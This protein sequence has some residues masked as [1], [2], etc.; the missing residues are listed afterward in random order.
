[1]I[2][3]AM[4]VRLNFTMAAMRFSLFGYLACTLN[5]PG[6]LAFTINAPGYLACTIN[7][8]S[9]HSCVTDKGFLSM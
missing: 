2:M 3:A 6:Y 5:A 1:M 8:P 7:A 4:I 9:Q